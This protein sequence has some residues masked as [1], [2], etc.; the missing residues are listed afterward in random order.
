MWSSRL[1]ASLLPAAVALTSLCATAAAA[2]DAATLADLFGADRWRLAGLTVDGETSRPPEGVDAT[3]AVNES[4][5]LAGSVGCNQLVAGAVLTPSGGLDFEPI[6]ATLMACPEPA[7][8][9]ERA[10]VDALG[11]VD[12]YVLGAGEVR[13]V[14]PGVEVVFESAA[15]G[16]G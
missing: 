10:F 15:G 14:G 2:G 13:L 5:Q 9:L 4:G 6:T 11:A 1:A 12:G 16:P 8:S 7:M 3:F